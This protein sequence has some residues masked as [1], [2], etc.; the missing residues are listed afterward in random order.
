MSP[1]PS[2]PP[3]SPPASGAIDAPDRF[4]IPVGGTGS[5]AGAGSTLEDSVFGAAV[6]LALDGF[7]W[8]IPGL[9]MSVPGLLV[10][11]AI[12]AQA[13]GGL[14]WLPVLRRKIGEFGPARRRIAAR[15]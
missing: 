15:S 6:A 5:G 8:Q 11:L 10:V 13:L 4:T 9:V 2:A 7:D 3:P 14:A 12:S 1:P